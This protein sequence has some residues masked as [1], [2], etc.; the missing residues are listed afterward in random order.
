MH[1]FPNIFFFGGGIVVTH[2]LGFWP[3]FTNQCTIKI[4]IFI[5]IM[6]CNNDQY[7]ASMNLGIWFNHLFS[8]NWPGSWLKALIHP[9]LTIPQNN[10]FS[11]A[12]TADCMIIQMAAKKR[13][14]LLLL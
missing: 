1:T 4:E 14:G 8:P 6:H 10:V 5:V 13:A 9:K 3:N 7:Y 12:R 11:L 2:S